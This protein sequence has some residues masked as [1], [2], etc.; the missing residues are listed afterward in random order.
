MIRTA[1]PA[2]AA[3]A[4]AMLTRCGARSATVDRAT[5]APMLEL[6]VSPANSACPSRAPNATMNTGSGRDPT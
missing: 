5:S 3:M 1:I 4:A 6:N 2:A